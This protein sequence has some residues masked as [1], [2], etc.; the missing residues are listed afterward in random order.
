MFPARIWR[1]FPQRYRLEAIQDKETKQVYFP[2][3]A[4]GDNF[5]KIDGEK[6]VLPD[7]GTIYTYTII[8]VPPSQFKD[9]APYVVAI[10]EL[11]DGTRVT[12]QIT[13][14]D[15][16]WLAIGKKVKL[17]FRRIQT[18]AFHGVLSYGYKAVPDLE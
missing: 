3:R 7:E 13:D 5:K 16:D 15:K 9:E 8:E 18:D 10:I 4:L 2:P 6:Y 1:E 17:E 14:Y 12:C 11:K